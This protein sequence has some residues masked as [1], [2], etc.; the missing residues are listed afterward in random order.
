MRAGAIIAD[1]FEHADPAVSL[2]NLDP[3]AISGLPGCCN[4][5]FVG[6][7]FNIGGSGDSVLMVEKIETAAHSSFPFGT[8]NTYQMPY[9]RAY[10]R[11]RIE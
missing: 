5:L 8:C 10:K 3:V 1:A 6:I 9:P 7:A 11:T 2:P 4:G